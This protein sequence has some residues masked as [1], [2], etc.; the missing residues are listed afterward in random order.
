MPSYILP[1][2]REALRKYLDRGAA[3]GLESARDL[4]FQALSLGL[5]RHSLVRIHQESL[6]TLVLPG[7]AEHNGESVLRRAGEFFSE[8]I[9]P[10]GKLRPETEGVYRELEAVID[11]LTRLTVDLTATNMQLNEEIAQRRTIEESLRISEGTTSDLL[12][13]SRQFQEDLRNLSWRLLTA[14]ENERRRISRELHDVITRTIT[15]INFHLDRLKSESISNEKELHRTLA[16][17]QRMVKKSVDVVHGFAHDMRPTILDDFGLIPALRSHIETFI[18]QTGIAV[19]FK[20][21][22][23]VEIP[24]GMVRTTLYRVA[25]EA[26]SYLAQHVQASRALI[27]IGSCGKGV[28]MEIVVDSKGS[29]IG[30]IPT[31]G[32]PKRLGLLGMQERV[33]MIDG[34]FSVTSVPGEKTTVSVDVPLDY[35][36][37]RHPDGAP[38]P[39]SNS[40][41][42]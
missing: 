27:T 10:M 35:P 21:F 26:L 11:A 7:S 3:S 2:Y 30:D 12:R 15:G 39:F 16:A 22:S 19:D 14:Q 20:A 33:E 32:Y 17:T 25:Q 28:R 9:K 41:S 38:R 29:A 6:E 18:E 42:I 1:I 37:S 5:Q 36:N 4:G 40:K 34:T 13:K 23:E 31:A 8:A 24:G